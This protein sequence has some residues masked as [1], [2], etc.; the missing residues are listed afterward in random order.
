MAEETDRE[1]QVR[2]ARRLDVFTLL[3][4]LATLGAS[5]YVLTDGALPLPGFDPRWLIAGA[6]VLV[7]LLLLGASFSGKKH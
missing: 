1:T 7:G 3:I 4:G 2:P 6:A 5:G